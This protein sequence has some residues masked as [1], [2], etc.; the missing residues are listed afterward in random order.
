MPN[1]LIVGDTNNGKSMIASRFHAAHPQRTGSSED[2]MILPILAIQAPP[3]PD[4]SRLYNAILEKLNEPYRPTESIDSR[5]FQ[6]VRI[7]SHIETRMF[8]H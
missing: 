6:A 3:V 2:S 7:L 4:E 1:L 5:Q 8:D